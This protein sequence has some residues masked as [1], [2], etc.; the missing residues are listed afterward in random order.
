MLI[1]PSSLDD[2]FSHVYHF[3]LLTY[4]LVGQT[5]HPRCLAPK[6]YGCLCC[7]LIGFDVMPQDPDHSK[8]QNVKSSRILF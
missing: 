5:I 1:F 4:F 6:G 7:S 8:S 2:E 3:K